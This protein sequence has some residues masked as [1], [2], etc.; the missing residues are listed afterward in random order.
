MHEKETQEQLSARLAQAEQQ[1]TVGAKYM[2][3]KQ[4]SYEVLAL[5]LRE[6]DNEP[7]VVYQAEYGDRITFIRPLA[8]WIEDVEVDGK[9]LKRFT[10]I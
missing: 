7:C 10:K 3:H 4:H 5:A 1:V 6:E 9:K 8:N 2:H